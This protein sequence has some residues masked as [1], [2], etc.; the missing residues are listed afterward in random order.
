MLVQRSPSILEGRVG[1]WQGALPP[2]LQGS[3]QDDTLL[4]DHHVH[5]V[6]A[7]PQRGCIRRGRPSVC[8]IPVMIAAF[9]QLSLQSLNMLSRVSSLKM[10][11]AQ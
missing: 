9:V 2:A 1:C 5:C 4:W 8:P 10:S 6:E 3:L 11:S 7:Q